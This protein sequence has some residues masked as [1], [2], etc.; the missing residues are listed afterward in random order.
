MIYYNIIRINFII[1]LDS[2]TNGFY[3]IFITKVISL[4]KS[5][6]IRVL[7]FSREILVKGFDSRGHSSVIYY[8]VAYCILD[9]RWI[10]NIPLLILGL[11]F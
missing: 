8:F 7:Y 11:G 10:Y 1:F 5:L 9:K 2:K 6:D 4:A 3:F